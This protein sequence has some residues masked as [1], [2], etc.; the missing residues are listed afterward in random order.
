MCAAAHSP[1]LFSVHL[2][3]WFAVKYRVKVYLFD[4]KED[5]EHVITN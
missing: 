5:K 1:E 2:E 3:G 4:T